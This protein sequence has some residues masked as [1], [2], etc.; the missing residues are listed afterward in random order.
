M[1]KFLFLSLM[2]SSIGV[3]IASSPALHSNPTFSF[4]TYS[5]KRNSVESSNV[6]YF[7][8][9]PKDVTSYPIVIMV[10]GSTDKQSLD[11]IVNFQHYFESD[12]NINHL[13][14]LAVDKW[15]IDNQVINESIV[16]KHYTRTQILN[17]YQ[18]V[19]NYIQKNPPKGWNGKLAI[20]GVSEGGPIAEKLAENNKIITAVVLWS[21]AID[22][23]W[24]D[25]LW[26]DMHEIYNTVCIPLKNPIADC[27]DVETKDKF[28]SRID[29]ILTKPSSESYFFNMTNMYVADGVTF[30]RPDYAKLENKNVLVVTG[31]KDTI[32]EASDD[33]N[34]KSK[35]NNVKIDYWRIDNMD[36][37]IRNRPD[38]ISNTFI[39]L[40]NQLGS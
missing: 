13:G 12:L 36:H 18:Q 17:D 29:Y 7:V 30:P 37:K 27:Y 15:G 1:R 23:S 9:K 24:R 16:M 19:I 39:W 3:A 34:K 21:G 11:S 40:S 14:T 8:S 10:G 5:I 28:E 26:L 20:L 35:Q 2:I 4:D 22:A 33:F 31:A 25:T 32:I 38:L 6:T